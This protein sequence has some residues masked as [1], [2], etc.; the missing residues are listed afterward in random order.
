MLQTP[1][2]SKTKQQ[3][4]IIPWEI[5][6]VSDI[7]LSVLDSAPSQALLYSA[8]SISPNQ[9]ALKEDRGLAIAPLTNGD[10]EQD[11]QIYNGHPAVSLSYHPSHEECVGLGT[12]TLYQ[13]CDKSCVILKDHIGIEKQPKSHL[14]KKVPLRI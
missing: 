5:L 6:P 12:P 13:S 4:K 9:L 8:T 3:S 14:V 1:I 2:E 11:I 7:Q 10:Q